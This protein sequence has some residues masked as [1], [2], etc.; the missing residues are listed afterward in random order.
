M[1]TKKNHILIVSVVL[2]L[3]FGVFG[4]GVMSWILLYQVNQESSNETIINFE[5]G[6]YKEVWEKASPAVVSIVAMKDLSE[7]YNQ[8]SYFNFPGQEPQQPQQ[9]QPDDAPELSEVSSGTGFI[10][11]ADG[12]VVTNKH[13]VEDT[14]AVYVV[15]L[16]DGTQLEAEV[17]DKDPL[18]DIALVQITGEDERLGDLPTLEF[19]DSDQIAVGDPVVA[20]G[21][22]LGEYSNTTTVG[23]VSAIG[24]EIIASSG[25]SSESLVNLIQTDAAINPGNSGGPLLNLAG[26]VIGMNTAIDTTASGIGF[27]LPSNDIASVVKS[28]QEFGHIV[29]PFVG[30]RYIP[31]NPQ[32]KQQFN[33]AVETG[34][35]VVSDPQ[36]GLPAVVEGSPAD[37]AGIQEGDVILSVND[38]D[39]DENYTLSNAI[40]GYMVGDTVTLTI[41]RKGEE[42]QLALTLEEN[43]LE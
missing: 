2:S 5:N 26:E 35:L 23:I 4:G 7:Y 25:Y 34:V 3:L 18:N 10:L 6:S 22:A 38:K 16:D 27:A 24:R 42:M 11:T 33:L 31:V 14:T 8:F 17:L 21:N 32:V 37:K 36:G 39:L 1:E 9:N 20:I 29:R 30:V 19:A 12:L 41:N 13:V 40:A 15:I 28:Y 43:Q